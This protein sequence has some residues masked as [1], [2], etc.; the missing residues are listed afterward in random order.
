VLDERPH[1]RLLDGDLTEGGGKQQAKAVGRGGVLDTVDDFGEK[2][3]VK[4]IDHHPDG[5]RPTLGQVAGHDVGAVANT[6]SHLEHPLAFFIADL[7]A[8]PHDQ[9]DEGPG[10]AGFA[11]DVLHCRPPGGP[12]AI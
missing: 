4:V 3:V 1:H 5:R 8:P 6:G 11:G 2:R 9:G 7:R 10:H 12:A